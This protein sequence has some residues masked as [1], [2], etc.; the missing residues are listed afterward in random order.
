MPTKNEIE[1]A[2]VRAYEAIKNATNKASNSDVSQTVANTLTKYSD[3]IQGVLNVFLNNRGAITQEQLD[4]LDE[5]IRQAKRKTLEAESKNTFVK[6]GLYISVAFLA[7][8]AL[9]IITKKK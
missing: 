4:D 8:G 7:F 1:N 2:I 6:Y 3:D 5:K 9:W